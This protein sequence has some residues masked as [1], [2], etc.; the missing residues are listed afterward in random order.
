MGTGQH[1]TQTKREQSIYRVFGHRI[2]I[3]Y[4]PYT[5]TFDL[6]DYR[7]ILVK[8]VLRLPVKTRSLYSF[9]SI[10]SYLVTKS[11]DY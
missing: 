7:R 2:E 11:L 9:L 4:V 1:T 5:R 10:P 6:A 3:N 8:K